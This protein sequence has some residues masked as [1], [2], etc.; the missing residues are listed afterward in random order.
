MVSVYDII[1]YGYGYLL[2]LNEYCY[3]L[4]GLGGVDM[5]LCLV[6]LW[7][8]IFVRFSFFVRYFFRSWEIESFVELGFVVLFDDVE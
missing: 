5:E 4:L 8:Y 7:Y 2:K 6:C 3:K 1:S